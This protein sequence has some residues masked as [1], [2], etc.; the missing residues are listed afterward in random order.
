MT[1]SAIIRHEPCPHCGSRDNL[2]RYDDGHGYCFGCGAYEAGEGEE[3]E[4]TGASK[5]LHR[6]SYAP[7]LSAVSAK[8]PS[9]SSTTVSTLRSTTPLTTMPRAARLRRSAAPPTR[10]SSGSATRK[11]RSCSASSVG[12]AG[13]EKS[14]SPKAS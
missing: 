11:R 9:A 14:S 8:R 10:N 7:L 5:A 3:A 6:G 12:K 1:E 4:K 13:V 2:G